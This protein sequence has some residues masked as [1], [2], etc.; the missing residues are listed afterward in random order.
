[1]GNYRIPLFPSKHKTFVKHLYNVGPT[2]STS[3]QH[4]TNVIQM[5]CIY[6][7]SHVL[8]R[9]YSRV[10]LTE[11][12]ISRID[13]GVES[14]GLNHCL[15]WEMSRLKILPSQDKR[16]YLPTL[17]VSRYCLLALQNKIVQFLSCRWYYCS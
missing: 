1:M 12:F 10:G 3:V 16:Q 2:S 17:Q 13:S 14:E 6:W 5:F 11:I 4:C 15:Y 7:V 8:A 9:L